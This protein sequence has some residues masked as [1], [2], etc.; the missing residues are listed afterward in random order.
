[1]RSYLGVFIAAFLSHSVWAGTIRIGVYE[2]ANCT[3][4]I[5]TIENSIQSLDPT[6]S[7]NIASYIDPITGQTQYTSFSDLQCTP[8]GIMVTK[9][10]HQQG[11]AGSSGKS[12]Y[13]YSATE[14]RVAPS[15]LG[16]VY[17]KLI[18]YKYPGNK[19]CANN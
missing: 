12:N 18:D 10:P 5:S 16:P 9:R 17:E 3:K 4:Y 14:C 1:M 19:N 2:D 15:H 6:K 8:D 7:C 13:V 11:C